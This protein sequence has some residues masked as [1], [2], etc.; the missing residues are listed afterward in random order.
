MEKISV[1][2]GKI[3][4]KTYGI[5]VAA[6]PAGAHSCARPPRERHQSPDEFTVYAQR[7]PGIVFE[8]SSRCV[9]TSAVKPGYYLS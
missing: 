1:T 2:Y 9:C 7:S 3:Q 5:W 6:V 4:Q 8:R